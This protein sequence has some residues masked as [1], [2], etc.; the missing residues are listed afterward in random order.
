MTAKV[1]EDIGKLQVRMGVQSDAL[2]HFK[3]SFQILQSYLQEAEEISK[4]EHE[5]TYGDVNESERLLD[6]GAIET[7]KSALQVACI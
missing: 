7:A 3:Q 4:G 5:L 6:R 1:H 2:N